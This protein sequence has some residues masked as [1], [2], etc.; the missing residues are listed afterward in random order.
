MRK[1]TFS[2]IFILYIMG[3]LGY[4]A[5]YSQAIKLH[6]GDEV[7]I[8]DM[9]IFID[10]S[11]VDNRTA[12][13][14][15]YQN[16]TF[17]VFEGQNKTIGNYTIEVI[18]FKDYVYLMISAPFNFHGEVSRRREPDCQQRDRSEPNQHHRAGPGEP[19]ELHNF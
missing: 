11:R 7:Y 2:L 4:V 1:L 18:P 5:A 8:D 9:H 10:K 19:D 3:T 13:V 16:S 6:V 17:L 15:E 12:A 14:I